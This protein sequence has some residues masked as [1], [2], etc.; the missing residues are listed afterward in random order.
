MFSR[1][2]QVKQKSGYISKEPIAKADVVEIIARI[3]EEIPYLKGAFA[4][5]KN[6]PANLEEYASI[7]NNGLTEFD[8][9]TE[10]AN[11]IVEDKEKIKEKST[12]KADSKSDEPG[13]FD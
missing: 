9:I 7:A 6:I 2:S 12:K 5:V 8:K 11:S 3:T 10:E 13:Y 4:R 1:T